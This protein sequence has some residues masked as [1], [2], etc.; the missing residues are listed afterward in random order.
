[1]EK[2]LLTQLQLH[3]LVNSLLFSGSCEGS[4]NHPPHAPGAEWPWQSRKHIP[5]FKI[6][7]GRHGYSKLYGTYAGRTFFLK[8]SFASNEQSPS[9]KKMRNCTQVLSA[10]APYMESFVHSRIRMFCSLLPLFQEE[11]TCHG[12]LTPY[13]HKTTPQARTGIHQNT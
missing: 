11:R 4:H 13:S 7:H 9:S 3:E 1:M 12:G 8:C 5:P 6:N 10:L 2:F